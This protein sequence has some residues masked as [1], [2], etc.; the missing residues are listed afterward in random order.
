MHGWGSRVVKQPATQLAAALEHADFSRAC[1]PYQQQGATSAYQGTCG[2]HQGQHAP[3]CW[4]GCC[5]SPTY[6]AEAHTPD[7]LATY[8]PMHLPSCTA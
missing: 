3:L 4:C 6:T 8:L 2:Q 1:I 5:I 7:I